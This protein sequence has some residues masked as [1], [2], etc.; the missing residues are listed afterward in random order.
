[1][2]ERTYLVHEIVAGC[3]IAAP[4]LRQRLALQ[5]DLLDDEQGPRPPMLLCQR[6]EA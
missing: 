5:E 1:M 3:A 4:V 2:L 6:I